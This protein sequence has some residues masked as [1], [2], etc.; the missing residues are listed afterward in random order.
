MTAR[1]SLLL[2][3]GGT[4]DPVHNGHVAVAQAAAELS[5]AAR[6]LLIPCG[7]PPHRQAPRASGALRAEL[8]RLAFAGD[9]RFVVDERE[10][11]RPGPSYMVDTL[12]DLRH[13]LGA[14]TAL[15]LLLGLDAAVGLPQWQRW[16]ELPALAHLLLVPRPSGLPTPGAEVAAA[17]QVVDAIDSLHDQPAGCAWVMPRAL[18]DASSTASRAALARADFAAADLPEAVAQ[19]LRQASPYGGSRPSAEK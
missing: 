2:V 8:L 14:E 17:W 19:R 3:Y 4:F 15:V 16:R 9:P 10:L 11:R 6:V 12:A 1:R 5:G 13:E 18:S 7:D